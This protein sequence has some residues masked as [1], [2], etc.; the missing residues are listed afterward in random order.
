MV[1]PITDTGAQATISAVEKWID[2]FKILQSIVHDRDSPF[3]NTEFINWT[4]ELGITLRPRTEHSPW[5]NGI[6]ET[7]NQLITRYWRI[8]LNDAGS[9][10]SSLARK[11]A[12]AHNTSVN[13]TTGKTPYEIV[14]GTK[15]QIPMSL[16]LGLHCIE[17]KLCFSEFCKHLL[18]HS[19]KDNNLK[20]QFLDNLFRPQLSHALLERKRDSRRFYS[21]TF[22]RCR[23]QTI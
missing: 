10:W 7:Q 8:S 23:E 11:F 14:F 16:N 19:H 13:Q 12:F 9:N 21:A 4:K 15:L 18:S 5:T 17:H 22:E 6:I 2:S 1:Y 3:F 20:N